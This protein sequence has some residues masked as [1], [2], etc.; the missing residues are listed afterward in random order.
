MQ[1]MME[2]SVLKFGLTCRE[3]INAST[4]NAAFASGL[5]DITGSIEIGKRADIA[6]YSVNSYEEMPYRW[7]VNK[8]DALFIEGK[9]ICFA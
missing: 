7:G 5:D 1:M 3:A 9:R 8:L 2:L 4:I 6:V